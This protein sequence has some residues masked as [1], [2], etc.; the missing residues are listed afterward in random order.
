MLVSY[1]GEILEDY[2]LEMHVDNRAFKFGDSVFETMK[3]SNGSL[4]F[5]EDHYFRLMSAMRIVRMEIPM[6]FSPEFIE[7]KIEELIQA[8]HSE[9]QTN[10]I[11]L[12]IVRQD[13]GLYTPRSNDIDYLIETTVIEDVEYTLNDVGLKMDVFKDHYKPKGL[14]SNIK[15]TNCL[16]Y[17]VAGI[18]ARENE[19]DD[20]VLINEDKHV[21]ESVSSNVFLIQGDKLI[22]PTIESGCLRGVIRKNI[23]KIAGKAELEV[24]ERDFSPFEIQRADEIFLTNAIKGIQWVSGFKKKTFTNNKVKALLEKLNKATN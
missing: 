2:E 9:K 10:R 4:N 22:T 16:I 12:S 15:T 6:N 14:L 24:E 21:V 19:L 11:R 20:V 8:K 18:Y 5:W 7:A 23:L 1:N 3:Y 13:G 17:T